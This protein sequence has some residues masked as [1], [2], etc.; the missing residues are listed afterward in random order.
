MDQHCKGNSMQVKPVVTDINY[1]MVENKLELQV[2][3]CVGITE[4]HRIKTQRISDLRLQQEAPYP[5]SKVTTLLYYAESGE[6]VWDIG[7]KCHASPECI[8][9]ENNMSDEHIH[10]NTVIVVPIMS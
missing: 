3:L 5:R 1:R 10:E 4:C 2:K 9:N 6:S 7:R 8:L